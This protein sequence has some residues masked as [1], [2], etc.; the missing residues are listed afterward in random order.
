MQSENV[1]P[2]L[3]FSG[4]ILIST[5]AQCP[6]PP[7]MKEISI[8]CEIGGFWSEKSKKNMYKIADLPGGVQM[9]GRRPSYLKRYQWRIVC[10]FSCLV[11]FLSTV[12]SPRPKSLQR[13]KVPSLAI[14]E[15]MNPL[16]LGVGTGFGKGACHQVLFLLVSEVKSFNPRTVASR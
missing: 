5:Q 12:S 1:K 2:L 3:H 4:K 16:N 9:L 15:N 7:P 14:T 11:V 6:L 13:Q 10:R 8:V